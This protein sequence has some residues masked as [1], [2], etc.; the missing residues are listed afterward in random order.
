MII[1]GLIVRKEK[2]IG[3]EIFI[4]KNILYNLR[5]I[6][7]DLLTFFKILY[8]ISNKNKILNK[9]NSIYFIN[10]I[11]KNII[12]KKKN[13]DNNIQ[14]DIII[15]TQFTNEYMKILENVYI[16]TK[17]F[18]NENISLNDNNYKIKKIKDNS[19]YLIY[20]KLNISLFVTLCENHHLQN[21]IYMSISH[22][23][24]LGNIIITE[25]FIYKYYC[26]SLKIPIYLSIFDDF[27]QNKEFILNNILKEINKYYNQNY[28]ISNISSYSKK[29]EDICSICSCD[30]DNYDHDN[31][32]NKFYSINICKNKHSICLYCFE[33]LIKNKMFTCPFC[34]EYFYFDNTKIVDVDKSIIFFKNKLKHI[35][36][37]IY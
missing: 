37:Y 13:Y 33:T 11:I 10:D 28:I 20:Y 4:P 6:S 16:I 34:R 2:N 29:N 25:D 9:I 23:N 31:L 27:S 5:E 1:S 14:L 22:E 35:N 19:F 18:N 17:K 32:K 21:D 30:N 26:K 7:N 24:P 8:E 15:N 3:L 12:F 36:F